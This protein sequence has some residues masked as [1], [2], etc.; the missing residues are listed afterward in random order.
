MQ[1][2][3]VD[4]TETDSYMILVLESRPVKMYLAL[5]YLSTW[6]LVSP[7]AIVPQAWSQFSVSTETK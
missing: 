2:S 1:A 5:L 6:D 4:F 3:Q 7:L